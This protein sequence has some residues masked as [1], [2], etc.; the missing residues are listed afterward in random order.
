MSRETVPSVVILGEDW[1]LTAAVRG[2]ISERW[3][4]V[5]TA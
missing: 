2:L 4:G 3:P 5:V 1:T